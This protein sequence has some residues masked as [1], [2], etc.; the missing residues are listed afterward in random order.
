[1]L[2][3]FELSRILK[4]QVHRP[5]RLFVELFVSKQNLP[6]NIGKQMIG[7]QSWYFHRAFKRIVSDFSF[8]RSWRHK[9]WTFY[10]YIEKGRKKVRKKKKKLASDYMNAYASRH[11]NNSKNHIFCRA[12]SNEMEVPI[13]NR[14][15]NGTSS[16]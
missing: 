10:G 1:M 11:I 7:I 5:I 4:R 14:K 9:T 12:R 8:F 13:E 3:S 15:T 16:G 6:I 2:F